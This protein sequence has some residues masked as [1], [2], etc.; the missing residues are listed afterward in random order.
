MLMRVICGIRVPNAWGHRL[1]QP[2]HIPLIPQIPDFSAKRILR[3][4]RH[5]PQYRIG[6]YV[7]WKHSPL[8]RPLLL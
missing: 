4:L 7:A 1:R 6:H 2:R 8:V 5:H 3:E